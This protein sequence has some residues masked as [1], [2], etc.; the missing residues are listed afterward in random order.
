AR[1]AAFAL[2]HRGITR[3]QLIIVDSEGKHVFGEEASEC[4]VNLTVLDNAMWG[5]IFLSHDLG[6]AEAYMQGNL[7]VPDLKA[8]LNARLFLDN[9]AGLTFMASSLNFLFELASSTLSN[10]IFRQNLVM[11]RKSAELSYDISNVF[12][13]CFLSKEMMYSA[14]LWGDAEHGPRGDLNHGP[15]EGDLERAQDRKIQHF[16]KNA[17][18]VPGDR[19][20]EIGSGWGA[21]AI[22]AGRMGCTV[23]SITL[24]KEQKKEADE[25][26]AAAG[27]SEFV[28][29]HLCDYREMPPSFEHAF[30]ACVSC[31]MLEVSVCACRGAYFEA[32]DWALKPDK[33]TVVISVST[34]PEDRYSEHQ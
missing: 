29:V 4:R 11:A 27:L 30:D 10:T 18:L 32:I 3:G 21:M 14:A 12:M 16:L 20:L 8:T 28:R 34:Q 2:V 33:A 15:T 26:I 31:E 9:R 6:F 23:D 7:E 5:Q 24:S 19:V 13:K 1:S 22:A 25:R 17:R